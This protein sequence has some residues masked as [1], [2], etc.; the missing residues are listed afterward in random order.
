MSA[1]QLVAWSLRMP[2][3]SGDAGG[4]L[5]ERARTQPQSDVFPLQSQLPALFA[6]TNLHAGLLVALLCAPAC[7]WLLFHTGADSSCAPSV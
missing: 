2:E 6:D 1:L 7:W 4:W 3:N 5:V